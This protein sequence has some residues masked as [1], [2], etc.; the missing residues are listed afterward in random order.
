[1]IIKQNM[2]HVV[3]A[4]YNYVTLFVDD[5]LCLTMYLMTIIMNNEL[6][7]MISF[8]FKFWI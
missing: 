1:M 7:I 6:S 3:D 4:H 8:V 2:D 5:V